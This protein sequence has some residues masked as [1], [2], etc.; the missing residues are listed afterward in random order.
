MI[1]SILQKAANENSLEVERRQSMIDPV[2]ER[3]ESDE[4]QGK[5]THLSEININSKSH[6]P[7]HATN[8]EMRIDIEQDTPSL[9]LENNNET[10]SS[11]EKDNTIILAT[12]MEPA[13]ET[14]QQQDNVKSKLSLHTIKEITNDND[15]SP[16]YSSISPF[17]KPS[18]D[19]Q[20][21]LTG[22]FK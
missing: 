8:Q 18:L 10:K 5:E 12:S 22:P 11:I 7:Q 14:N 4:N 1:Q 13:I 9:I 2:F 21:Q 15:L 19:I 16:H 17:Q 6:S 3:E 20:S